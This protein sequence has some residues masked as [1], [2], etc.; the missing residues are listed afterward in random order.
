MDDKQKSE[1]FQELED[2][3]CTMDPEPV[4][5]SLGYSTNRK[6]G[7]IWF[8]DRD[9]RTASANFFL[10]R[11]K[12]IWV[13]HDFGTGDKAENLISFIVRRTG[14]KRYDAMKFAAQSIGN[15]STSALIDQIDEII[16]KKSQKFNESFIEK[17]RAVNKKRRNVNRRKAV[18][19]SNHKV[20]Y[21]S[22]E[23][24]EKTKEFLRK[25]GLDPED[26][27]NGVY[28]IKGIQEGT[29]RKTGKSYEKAY[30]GVGV[31]IANDDT[32]IEIA[33][34]IKKDGKLDLTP[35]SDKIGAD[36]HLLEP[37][38]NKD[39]RVIKSRI[40]GVSGATFIYPEKLNLADVKIAVFESKMDYYAA[41]NQLD[42]SDF[43]IMVANGTG[44][45]QEIAD[46][47]DLL[48]KGGANIT[49]VYIFN[50]NDTV[51]DPSRL[52]PS[53]NFTKAV[54]ESGIDAKFYFVTYASGEEGK[55]INDIVAD[56]VKLKDRIRPI[57]LFKKKLEK[58]FEASAEIEETEEQLTRTIK[59][60]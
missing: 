10:S 53:E 48:Q 37:E 38:K 13:F 27:P 14:V 39:G 31:L 57:E 17:I 55:D 34:K 22:S 3:L 60:R 52:T 8:K 5:N 30:F 42:L 28:F 36:I 56:G 19:V 16:Q 11:T 7:R 49:K 12:G 23:F 25:R 4:L 35:Y 26:V 54:S 29:S 18:N 2:M 45:A 43:I 6:G 21:A 24:N 15:S 20:V 51:K 41:H 50:Q 44:H 46:K 32:M 9:E 47:F 58:R 33:G 1:L 40:F 59:W